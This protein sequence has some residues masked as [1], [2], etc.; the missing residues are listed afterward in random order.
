VTG[1]DPLADTVDHVAISRLLSTYAD[2]VDRRAWAELDGLFLPDAAVRIDPVT[3]EPIEVR[4]PVELGRFVGQ[5]VERYAF[6]EFVVLNARIDLPTA[7]APD[8]ARGRVFMCE[9]RRAVGTLEWS[10]AY[11]VYHDRFRRTSEGWRFA[12]RDYRSLTR[13]DGEVFP[14]V[15]R[16]TP[17]G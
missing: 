7:E 4:G 9:V 12:R 10:V 6:F 8:D 5:A 11:G 3:R 17:T 14:F 16:W 2:V 1:R 15:D 13:T